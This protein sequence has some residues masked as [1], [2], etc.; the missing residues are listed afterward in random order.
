MHQRTW[1][2]VPEAALAAASTSSGPSSSSGNLARV[3]GERPHVMRRHALMCS[4]A[5]HASLPPPSSPPRA[6][7]TM[8]S[9]PS[10]RPVRVCSVARIQSAECSNVTWSLG[11]RD[12]FSWTIS[13]QLIFLDD[14]ENEAV[15]LGADEALVVCDSSPDSTSLIPSFFLDL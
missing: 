7:R 5:H 15:F 14:Q 8:S 6:T 1:S 3:T 12:S 2:S 9:T 4:R 11:P 13:T 10:E